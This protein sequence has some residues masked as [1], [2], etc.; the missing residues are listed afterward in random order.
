MSKNPL[1]RIRRFATTADA[2]IHVTA[3]NTADLLRGA[4]RGMFA[5]MLDIARIPSRGLSSIKA[6]ADDSEELPIAFLNELLF[7][8]A[9]QGRVPLEF[10]Q[11]HVTQ[12][13]VTGTMSWGRLD[14]ARDKLGVEVKAATYS[15]YRWERTTD[16]RQRLR[17]VFDL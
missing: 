5:Y 3:G 14:P 15:L 11:L 6:S 7:I 16:G 4:V 2:G 13:K 1:Y 9:S 12:N 10:P 17:V 8:F